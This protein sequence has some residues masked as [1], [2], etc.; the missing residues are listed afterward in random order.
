MGFNAFTYS[1]SLFHINEL[2][3]VAALLILIGSYFLLLHSSDHLEKDL[4]VKKN[5]FIAMADSLSYDFP[6]YE[7]ILIDRYINPEYNIQKQKYSKL[8][9]LAVNISFL[10]FISIVITLY[11][12]IASLPDLFEYLSHIGNEI[13]FSILFLTLIFASYLFY[14]LYFDKIPKIDRTFDEEKISVIKLV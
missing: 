2:S 9:F 14:V 7:R 3:L 4:S 12:F 1:L 6:S 8:L 10:S 5:L 13:A 11:S